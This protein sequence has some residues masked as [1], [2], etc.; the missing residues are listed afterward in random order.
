MYD[1][2][3]TQSILD[4]LLS[5]IDDSMDK[6]PSSLIYSACAAYAQEQMQQYVNLSYVADQAHA[7][8][9]DRENLITIAKEQ[10][11]APKTA[12]ATLAMGKFN[13][14]VP[15]GTRF[16]ALNTTYNF[17]TIEACTQDDEDGFYYAEMRC[18]TTGDLTDESY[19]GLITP[20]DV[21][22]KVTEI[23]GLTTAEIVYIVQRG[24]N[25]EET[26][27]F[28]E[29]Y[30][31]ET[32]WEHYGGNIA[33]Y[34]LM[35]SRMSG[36]GEAKVIPVWAGGGTVKLV[37]VDPDML[38]PSEEFIAEAKEEIDPVEYEGLGYGKAPIDHTVTVVAAG[39]TTIN[40][41]LDITYEDGQ[42]WSMI[43]DEITEVIEAYFAETRKD[44]KESKGLVIRIAHIESAVLDVAGVLDVTGTTLNGQQQNVTVD[45]YSVP[46]LGTVGEAT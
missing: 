9:A 28:R 14:A 1:N 26:E 38:P 21:S 35:C 7:D 19:V 12:T 27:A 25:E 41:T 33:D 10:G 45:E 34:E 32:Q 6:R 23:E 22:G 3:S 18:E 20:I 37:L 39:K 40:V 44:W 5:A 31:T 46:I 24:E 42:D 16:S 30:F 36:I 11:I 43:G 15:Q 4:S 13:I 17:Y 8:T 2:I 29:R